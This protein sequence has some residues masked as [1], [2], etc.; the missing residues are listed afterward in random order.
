MKKIGYWDKYTRLCPRTCFNARGLTTF[1][2]EDRNNSI[3]K[4][5][6][7]SPL[8]SKQ[9][10][11]A[12]SIFTFICLYAP[13]F[14]AIA[15]TKI[16]LGV[17]IGF[18][19]GTLAILLVILA[20]LATAFSL[21]MVFIMDRNICLATSGISIITC[22]LAGCFFN[23]TGYNKVLD[24]LSNILPQKAFMI[25][26]KSIENGRPFQEFTRQLIYIV[27]WIIVLWLVGSIL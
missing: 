16:G 7:T 23:F 14:I 27:A 3:F 2:P 1:Y 20:S 18:G 26:S 5:I 6:L 17:E 9:Y 12:Q 15:V 22:I 11:V 8:G 25:L 13:T 19:L 10:L 4:R 21:F 24:V